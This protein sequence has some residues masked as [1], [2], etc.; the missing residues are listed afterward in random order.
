VVVGPRSA[1]SRTRVEVAG[2]TLY[3]PG[4]EVDSVKLRYRSAPVPT[5]VEGRPGAGRH[6][7]LT[8]NLD[9]PV[10]GVAPGQVACLMRGD[11][12]IGVATIRAQ[13]TEEEP[14]AV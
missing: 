11:D 10:Q 1:L 13:P 3:R 14:V 12:V 2:A 5:R 9:K 7:R 6:R 8:L 4:S